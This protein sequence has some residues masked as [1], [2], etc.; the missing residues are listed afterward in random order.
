MQENAVGFL[1]V[2]I[3]ILVKFI[4]E[5]IRTDTRHIFVG[6]SYTAGCPKYLIIKY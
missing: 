4:S 3:Y 6:I 1:S 5:Q 2:D